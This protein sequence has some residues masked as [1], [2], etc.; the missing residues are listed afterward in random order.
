[1]WQ[2]A[3]FPSYSSLPRPMQSLINSSRVEPPGKAWEEERLGRKGLSC[4][5][6]RNLAMAGIRVRSHGYTDCS[7]SQ[8]ALALP[9]NQADLTGEVCFSPKSQATP[10]YSSGEEWP[11]HHTVFESPTPSEPRLL[12]LMVKEKQKHR[13]PHRRYFGAS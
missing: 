3:V 5:L 12:F 10:P 11:L 8:C 6:Q 9:S 7:A 13:G 2:A 1:M 4:L